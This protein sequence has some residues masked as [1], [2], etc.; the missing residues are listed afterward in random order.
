[1][2]FKLENTKKHYLYKINLALTYKIPIIL[3]IMNK[4]KQIKMIWEALYRPVKELEASHYVLI[5]ESCEHCGF[6]KEECTGYK[7][8]IK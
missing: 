4:N 1:V 2:R 8:W 5:E 6:P 7:C 3:G